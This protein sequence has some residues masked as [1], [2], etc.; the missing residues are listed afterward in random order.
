MRNTIGMLLFSFGGNYLEVYSSSSIKKYYCAN[1]DIDCF[2]ENWTELTLDSLHG[3]LK[4]KGVAVEF[5]LF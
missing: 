2:D 4:E 5:N 1:L 3:S